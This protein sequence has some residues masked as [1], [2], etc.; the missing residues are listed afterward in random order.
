MQ[1][2]CAVLYGPHDLRIEDRPV[3]SPRPGEVLV[4]IAAVGI[5]GSGVPH[6]EHGR[7]GDHIVSAPMIIGH[8]SAAIAEPVSVI[9]VA[10]HAAGSGS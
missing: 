9:L 2:P 10:S 8:E 4:E 7:I 6:V 5:C 3:P 1:N